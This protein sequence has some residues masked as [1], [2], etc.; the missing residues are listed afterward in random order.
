MA[1]KKRGMPSKTC[2][3]PKCGAIMHA[4]KAICPECGKEQPI[5]KRPKHKTQPGAA[6]RRR[7]VAPKPAQ[8]AAAGLPQAISFV[9]QVGGLG[10]A[11]KLLGA[12]EEIKKL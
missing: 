5:A 3:D 1:K 11:K 6:K 4:R 12:I 2:I 10:H 9:R 8:S 7:R